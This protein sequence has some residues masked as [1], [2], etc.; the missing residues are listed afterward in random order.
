MLN[1]SLFCGAKEEI[2]HLFAGGNK[3]HDLTS[4]ESH[5][6]QAANVSITT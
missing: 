5:Q 6:I 1:T 3:T 2:L 4:I